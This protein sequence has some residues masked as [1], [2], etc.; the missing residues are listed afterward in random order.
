M[1][2]K[3]LLL[4][5]TYALICRGFAAIVKIRFWSAVAFVSGAIILPPAAALATMYFK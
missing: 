2:I 5:I 4:I 3:W 1:F